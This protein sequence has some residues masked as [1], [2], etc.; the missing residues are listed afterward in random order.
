VRDSLDVGDAPL[1]VYVGHIARGNDLDLALAA[2]KQVRDRV[3]GAKLAIAGAGDGLPELRSLVAEEGL[4]E[5]VI[6][7]GWI[8]HQLVP[9]YLAAADVAI[10]PYRDSLINRAKCS[11]KILEYMAMG[12]AIVTHRVGQNLEYIEDGRS[13]ILA[14]PGSVE[15]F[16]EGLIAVLTDRAFAVQLGEKAA[17]RIELK[18][19]W[20]RRIADVE[21][22]YQMA[23]STG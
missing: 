13:G 11:I 14:S 2:L 4:S 6:F 19:N 23:C 7:C 20:E 16:A 12:K 10:Y 22:A 1:A 15:E 9:A 3:P 18:F 21:R 8:D 5:A 17:R